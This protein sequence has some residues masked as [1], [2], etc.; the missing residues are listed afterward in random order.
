VHLEQRLCEE[1][2]REAQAE[3]E[4]AEQVTMGSQ[5][6]PLTALYHMRARSD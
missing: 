5:T 3:A 2:E 6:A 4:R 1:Q